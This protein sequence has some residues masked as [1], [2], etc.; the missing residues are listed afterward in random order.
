M[1]LRWNG[2]GDRDHRQTE[3]LAGLSPQAAFRELNR[4]G[5]APVFIGDLA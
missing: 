2:G 3:A 4:T 1:L 5:A